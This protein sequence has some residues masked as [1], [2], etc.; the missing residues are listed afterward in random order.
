VKPLD[1]IGANWRFVAAPGGI[2][3][4]FTVRV[5]KLDTNIPLLFV[6]VTITLYAL[7]A[8]RPVKLTELAVIGVGL[9]D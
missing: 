6:A 4:V 2:M 8:V 9:A 1:V 7:F 3:S 5:G